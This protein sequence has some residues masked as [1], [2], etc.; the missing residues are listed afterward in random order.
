MSVLLKPRLADRR[1]S[2]VHDQVDAEVAQRRG[3]FARIALDARRGVSGPGKKVTAHER[4]V[5]G[6]HQR[7][8]G[9]AGVLADLG[10]AQPA[11]LEGLDIGE[12]GG[13]VVGGD[14]MQSGQ[15]S[16]KTMDTGQ[17]EKLTIDEIISK[18]KN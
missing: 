10:R 17:Q 13:A 7:G 8:V 2:V 12:L 4:G 5:D 14:E 3:R 9:R 11:G 1:G 16:F 15:L 6:K 18:L